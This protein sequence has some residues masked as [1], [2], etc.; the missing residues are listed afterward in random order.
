MCREIAKLLSSPKELKKFC[1]GEPAESKSK[2][3]A[4]F[5]AISAVADGALLIVRLRGTYFVCRKVCS[6]GEEDDEMLVHFY[7]GRGAEYET[8]AFRPVYVD[9][10]DEKEIFAL[11]PHD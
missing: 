1:K 2:P 11:K 3:I 7:N 4:V 8:R 10:R 5:G 6:G 9:P